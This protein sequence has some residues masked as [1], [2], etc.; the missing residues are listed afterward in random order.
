LQVARSV[1]DSDS[2]NPDPDPNRI[3]GFDDPKLKKI[4]MKFFKY[5]FWIKICNLLIPSLLKDVQATGKAFFLPSREKIQ[6][7]KI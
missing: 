3:K 7:F 5:F 4:Q 2:M 1:V 6:H